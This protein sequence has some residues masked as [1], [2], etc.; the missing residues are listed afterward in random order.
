MMRDTSIQVLPLPAQASMTTLRPGSS[1]VEPGSFMPVVPAAQAAHVAVLAGLLYALGPQLRARRERVVHVRE[2]RAR[3][4]RRL[5]DALELDRAYPVA[6][7]R[8]VERRG[9]GLI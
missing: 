4:P 9:H 8:E 1:G 6:L 2:P 7:E 3:R 5:A